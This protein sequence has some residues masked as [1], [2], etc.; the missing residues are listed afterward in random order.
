MTTALAKKRMTSL[1]SV[2]LCVRGNRRKVV[3]VE[4]HGF[5]GLRPVRVLVHG[6]GRD[7]KEIPRPPIKALLAD[8]A[9]AVAAYNIIDGAAGVTVRLEPDPRAQP[10]QH[11]ANGRQGRASGRR[12]LIFER[13]VVVRIRIEFRGL[14]Q[15][16]LGARPCIHQQGI[17]ERGLRRLRRTHDSA[18]EFAIGTIRDVVD[19]PAR[20]IGWLKEHGLQLA[21]QCDVENVEPNHGC[22]ALV[23]MVVERPT[24]RQHEVALVHHIAFTV[25]GRVGAFAV[26]NES[27]G[28][29]RVTVS[30][31]N[32]AGQDV[33]D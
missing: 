2:Y 32:L 21:H 5:L 17:C 13:G 3:D 29:R 19:R 24:R 26:H 20:E 22:R 28:G 31:R 12:I 6:P 8:F 23:F 25:D 1:P 4:H 11:C 30:G 7:R 9:R 14:L 18:A 16:L 33:L 10:L 15:R 27:Q